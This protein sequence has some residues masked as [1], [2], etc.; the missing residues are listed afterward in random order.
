MASSYSEICKKTIEIVQQTGVFIKKE[1]EGFDWDKIEYK[2]V[3]NLVSYV[4]KEAEKILV[5]G[6]SSILPEAG[7]ITEEGTVAQRTNEEYVWLIDPLDGTTNFMHGLPLY[8]I[9]VGLMRGNEMV[10]GVI[11]DP[12]RGECFHAAKGEGAFCNNKPIKVSKAKE[13]SQSLLATG[14]PY[15]DFEKVPYFL[16]VLSDFMKSSHGIRRCGSAAIDLAWVACGRFE[17]YYE[18][19]INSWDVA[20]GVLIVQEAG[21]K[22][23]DFM[24]GD[25]YIFSHKIVASCGSIHD[26]LVGTIK[27]HWR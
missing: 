17:A 19:S 27:K 9:S 2:G 5:K 22:V 20:A 13:L 3:N 6:L 8:S 25:D 10:V 4:D 24:G 16:N 26:D 23:T 15:H 14:F 7:Y 11:L 12:S 18:W 1:W 21:G